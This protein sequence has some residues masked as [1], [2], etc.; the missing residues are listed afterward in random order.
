MIALAF[1][2]AMWQALRM[3]Q[4]DLRVIM[5]PFSVS[6][7]AYLFC[8]AWSCVV[9]P[10]LVYIPGSFWLRVLLSRRHILIFLGCYALCVLFRVLTEL[11]TPIF[12]GLESFV[13]DA[14]MD[15]FDT[16]V[17]PFIESFNDGLVAIEFYEHLEE[18][19]ETIAGLPATFLLP[20]LIDVFS[21]ILVFFRCIGWLAAFVARCDDRFFHALEVVVVAVC[22]HMTLRNVSAVAGAVAFCGTGGTL[23]LR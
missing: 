20:C 9:V 22:S 19:I 12:G 3:L 10:A 7:M 4:P 23:L 14:V 21:G 2:V 11:P 18:D 16:L 8:P 15:P 17:A 1:L 5:D 6:L 13:L